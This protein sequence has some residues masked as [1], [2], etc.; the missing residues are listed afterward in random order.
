[1]VTPDPAVARWAGQPIDL[2]NGIF[3]P[4]VIGPEGIPQVADHDQAAREPQL[5]VL[6]VVATAVAKSKRRCRSRARPL[7]PSCR[8]RTS[9]GCYTP[10]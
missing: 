5:A 1:V 4:R 8:Y 10:C 7:T 3:V 9:S 2:G 6:S